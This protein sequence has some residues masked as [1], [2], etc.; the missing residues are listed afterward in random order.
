MNI[1]RFT[2]NGIKNDSHFIA[3]RQT[4]NSLWRFMTGFSSLGGGRLNINSRPHHSPTKP[5]NRRLIGQVSMVE[6]S[7]PYKFGD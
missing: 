1:H 2:H 7:I 6:R 5:S 4:P 3:A